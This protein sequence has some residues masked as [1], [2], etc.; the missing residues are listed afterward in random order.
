MSKAKR[1]I[2]VSRKASRMATT[3]RKE[4]EAWRTM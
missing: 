3:K 1:T 2:V 4:K